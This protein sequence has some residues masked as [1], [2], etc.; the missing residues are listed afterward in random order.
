M[1]SERAVRRLALAGL[2]G[3]I[4]ALLTAPLNAAAQAP[5]PTRTPIATTTPPPGSE[6]WW[7]PVAFQGHA[8]TAVGVESGQITVA[9]DGAGQQQ[10]SDGG[11]TW[12]PSTASQGTQPAA[13]PGEWLARDDRVGRIDAAGTWQLDPGSPHVAPSTIA[14]H[15]TVAAVPGRDGLVVAVDVDG[16]VWRRAGDGHWA[17]AL[18]LLNQDALHGPPQVTGLTSFTAPLTAAVYLATD[19]YSVL[20]STDGG[21]DWFRGGPGLPDGV[22]AITTDSPGRAVYAATRDGLWLHHLQATPAPPVYQGQDLRLRWIG[23][24]AVSVVAVLLG[25]AGMFRLLR[26]PDAATT[27]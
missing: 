3:S 19:G 5:V 21:D 14:G 8:V 9:V 27:T 11:K 24:G 4:A 25:V 18:L 17:R 22:L 6:P 2:C 12:Q 16:V 13:V 7:V 26:P 23:I 1:A 20:E 15:A 10:S